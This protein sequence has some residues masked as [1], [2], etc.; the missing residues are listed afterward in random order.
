MAGRS[1]EADKLRK[2]LTIINDPSKWTAHLCEP[3]VTS[4]L[5]YERIFE[6]Q[7]RF[8]RL[9][10]VIEEVIS[11]AEL[12]RKTPEFLLNLALEKR[13]HR[14]V[15]L[16]FIQ[17]FVS[18]VPNGRERAR[19]VMAGF[20][21]HL[22][23]IDTASQRAPEQFKP[24]IISSCLV[25]DLSIGD[26][27]MDSLVLA[28]GAAKAISKRPNLAEKTK[29]LIQKHFDKIPHDDLVAAALSSNDGMKCVLS[30]LVPLIVD[31]RNIKA[32]EV[33]QLISAAG[34]AGNPG[35][36][37]EEALGTKCG[38]CL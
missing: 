2:F 38:I 22:S 7:E 6:S 18:H 9:K 24:C 23:L 11:N 21:Q 19:D 1:D 16:A 15:L 32:R 37:V 28:Q 33:L 25:H 13:V 10:S 36:L 17:C 27:Q 4:S 5:S 20:I 34:H 26:H 12:F 35:R 14:R 8:D 3:F 29:K 30:I 31:D